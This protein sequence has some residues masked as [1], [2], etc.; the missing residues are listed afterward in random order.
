MNKTLLSIA[1]LTLFSSQALADN[2][3]DTRGYQQCEAE[4]SKTFSDAG[5]T[6]KRQYIVKRTS[7]AR[8]FYINKT[9]WNDGIRTPVASTCV[10]SPNGR[11]VLDM[12]SDFRPH[13]SVEELVAAR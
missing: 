5:V 12:E 10:T 13:V 4:L 11:D 8:T 1:A 3:L 7:E 9:I 2:Y 6:Y